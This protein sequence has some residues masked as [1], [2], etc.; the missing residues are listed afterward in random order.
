MNATFMTRLLR[1]AGFGPGYDVG[2]AGDRQ[3][4]IRRGVVLIALAATSWGTTGAATAVLVS[5]AGA[6]PLLIGAVRMV[7]A[8]ALLLGMARLLAGR[9]WVPRADLGRCAAAGACMAGF[10]AAYFT[11]VTLGGIA[12]TALVAICSAPLLIAALAALLLDEPLTARTAGA[13]VLGVLGTALLAAGAGAGRGPAAPRLLAGVA[14]AL[15]AGLAYALYVIV[16]KRSLAR[17]APLP[18]TATTFAGA[19]LLAAPALAVV[20]APMVQIALGWPWLLYLGAVATAGAYALYATGLV[21]VPASV[22]GLVALMEPLT[23]TLLGVLVFGER[24]GGLG[25]LGAVLLLG[26]LAAALTPGPGNATS[27]P[28]PTR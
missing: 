27:G 23:A 7:V 18:L 16:T 28:G 5:R 22:A 13:L 19:A 14:L 15:G 11:A 17:A 20:E 2:L 21:L 25:A 8:A 24:L 10:Q 3:A 1:V 26:A 9:A 6:H 12:V 4:D